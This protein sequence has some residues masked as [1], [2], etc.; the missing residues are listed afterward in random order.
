MMSFS[1]RSQRT[2]HP[3]AAFTAVK[4]LDNEVHLELLNPYAL[5]SSIFGDYYGVLFRN[6]NKTDGRVAD[7]LQIWNWKSKETFQ[8]TKFSGFVFVTDESSEHVVSRSSRSGLRHNEF[9]FSDER[10]TSRRQRGGTIVVFPPAYPRILAPCLAVLL[11][12]NASASVPFRPMPV[13]TTKSSLSV[14]TFQGVLS[15]Q[16]PVSHSMSNA[17]PSWSSSP[18]VR[19]AV[20]SK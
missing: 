4:A 16:N 15:L 20:K 8:V 12:T 5:I 3:A 14:W 19:A 7:F 6:V 13:R 11:N 18:P 17:I 9:Q 1:D 10:K 2:V